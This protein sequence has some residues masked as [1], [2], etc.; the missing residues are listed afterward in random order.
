MT[1]ERL[2][3]VFSEDVVEFSASLFDSQ[4]N[5]PSAGFPR[6]RE[7]A[8]NTRRA[9]SDTDT[10][11]QEA[12]EFPAHDRLVPRIGRVSSSF[13]A[14]CIRP[15]RPSPRLSNKLTRP[16]SRSATRF[17][18]IKPLRLF[19]FVNTTMTSRI[20]M[21]SVSAPAATDLTPPPV[22]AATLNETAFKPSTTRRD[23]STSYRAFK[24]AW[25]AIEQVQVSSA[26]CR[27]VGERAAE[28]LTAVREQLLQVE[29]RELERQRGKVVLERSYEFQQG[30]GS[31]GGSEVTIFK[32]QA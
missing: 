26:A 5:F 32:I 10:R 8:V 28:V 23:L 9:L 17:A 1:I 22:V 14:R 2:F 12:P 20:M 31:T 15:R 25:S 18:L 19:V 27:R 4:A 7:C 21:R 3:Q 30:Q 13:P 16:P 29:Q 24:Q 11:T 6:M